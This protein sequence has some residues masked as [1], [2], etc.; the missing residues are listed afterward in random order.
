LSSPD[1]RTQVAAQELVNSALMLRRNATLALI[2][3]YVAL[4]WPYGELSTG[5]IVEGYVQ[6]SGS[7]MLLGRL[8]NPAAPVRL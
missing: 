3:I 6:L 8:Q 5:R 2:R 1:P 4:A 7:A